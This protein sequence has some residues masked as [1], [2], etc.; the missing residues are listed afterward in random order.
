MLVDTI[1]NYEFPAGTEKEPD[2]AQ[3]EITASGS[4][5]EPGDVKFAEPPGR[6]APGG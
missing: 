2:P 5:T 1:L 3:A 4:P 6:E